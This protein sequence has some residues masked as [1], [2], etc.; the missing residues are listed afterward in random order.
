[1]VITNP[2]KRKRGGADGGHRDTCVTV[3]NSVENEASTNNE[4]AQKI[5]NDGENRS[6]STEPHGLQSTSLFSNEVT[7]KE[8]SNNLTMGIQSQFRV[9]SVKKSKQNSH[10]ATGQQRRSKN[11]VQ[12]TLHRNRAFDP[13]VHC[14]MCKADQDTMLGRIQK[15]AKPH[16]A[17]H[18]L[19]PKK[20]V[21]KNS[22][23]YLWN[24]HMR[25]MKK[26]NT[27]PIVDK[28]GTRVEGGDIRE[29]FKK[30]ILEDDESTKSSNDNHKDSNDNSKLKDPPTEV[31]PFAIEDSLHLGAKLRHAL[32]EMVQEFKSREDWQTRFETCGN[33]PLNL[34][35]L[36]KHIEKETRVMRPKT[37][38]LSDGTNKQITSLNNED[39]RERREQF[40]QPG[41]CIFTIP[42]DPSATPN[43][44]FVAL[45]GMS[46]YILCWNTMF[47]EL[48]FQSPCCRANWRHIRTYFS[49]NNVLFPIVQANGTMMWGTSMAC[50]CMS[51]KQVF[52]ANNH[53]LL[54]SLPPHVRQKCPVEPRH[55]AGDRPKFHLSTDASDE[56]ESVMKTCGNAE[57]FSRKLLHLAS[58]Q[59]LRMLERHAPRAPNNSPKFP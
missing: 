44:E 2:C 33:V 7:N 55:A 28:P 19:C 14:R 4:G 31:S 34:W 21:R 30:G 17:H 1:M 41:T 5:I 52:G 20:K 25:Q 15:S 13:L 22:P 46:I 18:Y 6:Q 24:Q 35:L 43:P 10:S 23:T 8:N 38:Q 56:F 59:Y 29:A 3:G 11:K 53:K 57:F 36:F 45:E 54:L 12:A 16:C 26:L 47:P 51:C 9:G 50:R 32:E 48:R 42:E 40:F 58:K 39:A 27:T 49:W 37:P